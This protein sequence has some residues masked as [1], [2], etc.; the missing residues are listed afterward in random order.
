MIHSLA[1]GLVFAGSAAVEAPSPAALRP[2]AGCAEGT[3]VGVQLAGGAT[4]GVFLPTPS[5]QAA[6]G[7]H[8]IEPAGPNGVPGLSVAWSVS[9]AGLNVGEECCTEL[10]I[11]MKEEHRRIGMV[12][13][14]LGE[15]TLDAQGNCAQTGVPPSIHGDLV[16]CPEPQGWLADHDWDSNAWSSLA[17]G[18]CTG[19]EAC[20][21]P[22]YQIGQESIVVGRP[23]MGEVEGLA[24][25]FHG[26]EV[27]LTAMVTVTAWKEAASAAKPE[28]EEGQ[29]AGEDK[30]D[31]VLPTPPD[32]PARP[33]RCNV[34]LEVRQFG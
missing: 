7:A 2:G 24:T 19:T 14:G 11:T 17:G 30:P 13:L 8:E 15:M 3:S 34:D 28:E 12:V 16:L 1:V 21:E 32:A 5:G 9:I 20:C 25:P 29:E 23:E 18:E 4:G 22:G 6:A 33:T 31:G 10:A 26:Y 27:V